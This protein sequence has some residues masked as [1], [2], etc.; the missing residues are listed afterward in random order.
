M[1]R[2]LPA[3]VIDDD[4]QMRRLI[5]DALKSGGW[6][7]REAENA[8]RAFEILP[9]NRW[10]LVF[11]DVNLGGTNGYEVLRRFVEMQPQ[12][13]FF[14]MTGY[15]SA[16]G[17]LEAT[18]L[19]AYDYLVKPFTVNDILTA[20]ADVRRDFE[21]RDAN[22]EIAGAENPSPDY[23]ADASLIGRSPT[24]IECMKLVGRVAPTN[25]PVLISGESGTGKEIIARAIHKRS[26]RASNAFVA[27]N[28]GALPVDLIESEL[29]GHTRGSFTGASS[30]R[31]G[32]WEEANGGTILLDEITETSS[33]FQ[34]KLLRALQEGEI[35]RVGSN[36]TSKVDVR[37]IA[38]TNRD[39]EKEVEAG[40][41][42]QDLMYRLNVVTIN[43]PP[44]RERREDIR[45][46][47]EHF[48]RRAR[49]GGAPVKFSVEA[50]ETLENYDWRG[51]IRELENA[52][53][54]AVS[55]C[56]QEVRSE[57]L[58]ARVRRTQNNFSVVAAP[59]SDFAAEQKW[60]QLHELEA[61]YVARVLAHTGGN[62][63]AAAQILGIDRKRLSR[64]IK[65]YNLDYKTNVVFERAS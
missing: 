48:A 54:H 38:A 58:P 11:C 30:E 65:R 33:L 57:H 29:F 25:M 45:V 22:D 49:T 28:C 18:A 36:R 55:V 15:Q 26:R 2:N 20:A 8:D 3:I 56:E 37:V 19:G 64:I 59:S 5:A 12:A 6:I 51:N 10:A 42:R 27:V 32:L 43:L 53:F 62:K 41:F 46:L 7:V 52:V 13:R 63:Q 35:R 4:P 44:L 60:I 40:R 16:S 23:V 61:D 17:A 1:K 14:L 50:L 39:I 21:R 31:V 47:A 24:F 34:I 9:E